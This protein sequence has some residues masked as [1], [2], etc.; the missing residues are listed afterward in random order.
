LRTTLPSRNAARVLGVEADRLESLSV[1]GLALKDTG[2]AAGALDVVEEI[3]PALDGPAAPGVVQPGRVLADVHRVLVCAGDAR[4]A[5]VAR[6]SGAYL[7][8][9]SERI[10]DGELRARFLAT[11]VNL[12]L[13]EIAATVAA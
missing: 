10:R 8:E 11:P 7:R 1:L 6:R 4:A 13:A 5:D 12:R 3:L 9:Q 2:D